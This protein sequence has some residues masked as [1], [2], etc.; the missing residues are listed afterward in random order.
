[1]NFSKNVDKLICSI[2]YVYLD[3]IENGN[4]RD[5]SKLFDEDFYKSIDILSTTPY[6]DIFSDLETISKHGMI[7]L[8]ISGSFE[9]ND[10]FIWYM[11]NRFKNGLKEVL[12]FIS[13]IK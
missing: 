2:Y 4:S 11:E 7:S 5:S 10:K 13:F 3:K 8:F 12:S 6:E 9:I 1:M